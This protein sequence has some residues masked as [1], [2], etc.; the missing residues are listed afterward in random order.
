MRRTKWYENSIIQW[1][2]VLGPYILTTGIIAYGWLTHVPWK[3]TAVI[4]RI[5]GILR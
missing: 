5:F 2:W 4:Y 3:E 1:P